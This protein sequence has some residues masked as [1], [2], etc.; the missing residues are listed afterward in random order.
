MFI[1]PRFRGFFFSSPAS[2]RI[3]NV[4]KSFNGQA[5]LQGV[6]LDIPAGSI[7][8]LLGPS[9]CGKTT[10]LRLIGGF[11]RLYGGA[12][13]FDS[14][15]VASLRRHVPPERRHQWDYRCWR[16][17]LVIGAQVSEKYY[18]FAHVASF[19]LC[20]SLL[21]RPRAQSNPGSD[22]GYA[23]LMASGISFQSGS[24][25]RLLTVKY[26]KVNSRSIRTQKSCLSGALNAQCRSSCPRS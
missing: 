25:N 19:A 6:D 24:L 13:Q 9:G 11:D 23:Y 17:T 21:I 18:C 20:S 4:T 3:Q 26:K 8:A 1:N 22:K 12:I 16:K 2:L 14:R 15:T 7:V 10:L 5:V